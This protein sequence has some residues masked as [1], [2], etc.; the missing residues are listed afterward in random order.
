VVP[1]V[2]PPLRDRPG[3]VPLLVRHF[4]H[5][6]KRSMNCLSRDFSPEAMDL[7][8][9]YA[10]PGN[11]RELRNVVERTLVMHGSCA[12][13]LPEHLPDFSGR[14]PAPLPALNLAAVSLETS[15]AAY[16]RTLILT[17][18]KES[19]GIQTRAA[20]LLGTTRRILAY[21]MQKLN[22]RGQVLAGTGIP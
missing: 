3:D 6:L 15:V 17:A 12:V 13:I 14:D 7:L 11:I 2:L 22:L 20:R 1:I 16:E 5:S 19:R 10:W 8:S 9:R 21:K 4:L 18:L